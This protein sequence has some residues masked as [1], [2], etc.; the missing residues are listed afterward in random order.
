MDEI[1]RLG[2]QSL[3]LFEQFVAGA[4]SVITEEGVSTTGAM[5]KIQEQ[6]ERLVQETKD[7]LRTFRAR[8]TDKEQEVK[9]ILHPPRE[10][11]LEQGRAAIRKI[12]QIIEQLVLK[13]KMVHRW[14]EQSGAAIV[15]E[16]EEVLSEGDLT[17]IEVFESEAEV[18][19]AGKGD[20]EATSKFLSLRA[21]SEESRLSPEQKKA[22]ETLAELER[23]KD[24]VAVV[25][26]L[27]TSGAKA[28]GD[29]A[30][31]EWRQ[32]DRLH[33][34]RVDQVGVT[35]DL[36]RDGHLPLHVTLMEISKGGLR[37]RSPEEVSLGTL[38]TLSLKYPGVADKALSLKVEVEWCDKEADQPG[39][40]ALGLKLVEE[41]A[42]SWGELFPKIV[43]QAEA[44]HALLSSPFNE[45]PQ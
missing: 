11:L 40:Y 44:F 21:T 18:Y 20:L 36:H 14:V 41:T 33:L 16:Y 3:Q 39:Q 35:A 7:V 10:D 24:Q 15:A 19:L 32:E 34:G 9:A 17:K 6:R 30:P 8:V 45:P 12:Y 37:V 38:L 29:L 5:A 13:D 31:L 43:E 27:F 22:K 4:R 1:R 23:I 26:T 25:V 2:R 28:Y 42:T